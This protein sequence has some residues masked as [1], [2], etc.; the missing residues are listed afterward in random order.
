M[1]EPGD[2]LTL[3]H[4]RMKPAYLN[5]AK[6]KLIKPDGMDW[7]GQFASTQFIRWEAEIVEMLTPRSGGRFYVG[8]TI[9]V[10]ECYFEKGE[11]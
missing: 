1:Y 6:V 2:V 8:G 5:G 11:R 3:A 10:S 4:P 7:G 9:G